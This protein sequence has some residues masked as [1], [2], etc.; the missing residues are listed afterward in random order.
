MNAKLIDNKRTKAQFF[1]VK[2]QNIRQVILGNIAD[3]TH[4]K[5]NKMRKINLN[6]NELQQL[7]RVVTNKIIESGSD[8]YFKL[9]A[10]LNNALKEIYLEERKEKLNK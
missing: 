4:K 5:I 6:K 2:T 3:K 9:Q 8:D 10:K 7:F 1:R